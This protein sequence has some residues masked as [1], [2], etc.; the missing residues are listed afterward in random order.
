MAKMWGG[1]SERDIV[2]GDAVVMLLL[3]LLLKWA[4]ATLRTCSMVAGSACEGVKKTG[5]D[6][7]DGGSGA[8]SVDV[9]DSR[10]LL[11]KVGPDSKVPND[12]PSRTGDAGETRDC[13]A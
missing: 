5:S 1:A 7:S 13:L 12:V 10:L 4:I 2:I 11:R 8:A 6:D 3:Q 9:A